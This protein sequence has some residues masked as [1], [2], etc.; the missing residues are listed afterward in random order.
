MLINSNKTQYLASAA[1]QKMKEAPDRELQES[2]GDAFLGSIRDYGVT[3]EERLLAGMVQKSMEK[4]REHYKSVD[5]GDIQTVAFNALAKGITG[6]VGAVIAEMGKVACGYNSDVSN[7]YLEGIKE[8][9]TE[10]QK[11]V[12]EFLEKTGLTV[13]AKDVKAMQEL[14][15]KSLKDT[16]QTDAGFVRKHGFAIMD[17]LNNTYDYDC[18]RVDSEEVGKKFIG[19]IAEKG[20][21]K[22]KEFASV[23]KESDLSGAGSLKIAMQFITGGIGP[24]AK[25]ALLEVLHKTGDPGLF[26]VMFKNSADPAI[27]SVIENLSRIDKSRASNL[28]PYATQVTQNKTEGPVEKIL[29][30]LAGKLP[31][32]FSYY[33]VN[34]NM[35]EAFLKVIAEKAEKPENREIARKAL[36]KAKESPGF[37]KGIFESKDDRLNNT[38][39]IYRGAFSEISEN[40]TLNRVEQDNLNIQGE[41]NKII[42]S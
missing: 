26:G 9:G 19:L 37:F 42:N 21:G 41:I 29:I 31:D 11:S 10:N 16:E 28:V 24:T 27:L 23:L 15:F 6:P 14:I 22:E 8:H 18:F 38:R 36:D 30:Q 40:C 4:A 7:V 32:S 34:R 1:L 2:R 35:D 17:M 25:K 33:E 3:K 39:E 12:V 5:T 13:D 20:E